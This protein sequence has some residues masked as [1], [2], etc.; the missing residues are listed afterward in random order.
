MR[1]VKIDD[2][3]E[4]IEILAFN[5]DGKGS[6]LVKYDDSQTIH[7]LSEQEVKDVVLGKQNQNP[8]YELL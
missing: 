2:R 6:A 7:H 4:V 1:L 8:E 5:Y 3:N